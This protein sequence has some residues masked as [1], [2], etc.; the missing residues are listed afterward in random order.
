MMDLPLSISQ[1]HQEWVHHINKAWH[2][3]MG[4]NCNNAADAPL[5]DTSASKCHMRG[6]GQAEKQT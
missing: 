5:I 6:A 1:A 4:S 2:L 3:L